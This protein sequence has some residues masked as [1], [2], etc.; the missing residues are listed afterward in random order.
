M[1]RKLSSKGTRQYILLIILI[2][3]AIS[4]TACAKKEVVAK[5]NDVE[6]TKDELYEFLVAQYGSEALNSLISEKIVDLEVE[7]QNIEVTDEDIQA[8]IDNLKASYGGEA[9]FNSALDYYGYTMDALTEDIKMNIKIEKLITPSITI[10][11]EEMQDYFEQN[12]DLLD[13]QEEVWASH[14]LVET[15]EEAKEVKEKLSSGGDFSE[16]AK[17]Y[18]LDESNKDY[19]GDLGFFGRGEMVSEFEDVAF[20]LAAGEISDPVQTKFGYHIIKVEEKREAKEANY[21][22]LKEDIR[23]ILL[24]SKL[25]EAYN[26]WY[27]E[28]LNEYNIDSYLE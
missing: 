14:I 17:E 26:T 22:E 7:K 4:M 21:E 13:Q 18:S 9:A 8:K 15:E 10:S 1:I 28:K 12:K 16:L 27:Q 24:N 5:V 19:G 2:V 3:L 23:E 20:S 11:D 25:P 6:I